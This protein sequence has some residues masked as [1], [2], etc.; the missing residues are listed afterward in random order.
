MQTIL[1]IHTATPTL[2]LSLLFLPQGRSEVRHWL[3]DRQMGARLHLCLQTFYPPEHWG[4]LAAIAVAVGPGS[5]TGC[6]LGV[7]LARTLGCTLEIPVFGVSTLAAVACTKFSDSA[8]EN[9]LAIQM[10]AKRGEWF[11]GIYS[12]SAGDVE[13]AIPDRLWSPQEWDE[14]TAGLAIADAEQWQAAPPV[15]AIALLAAHR[16]KRGLRPQWHEVQPLYGRQPP[17]QSG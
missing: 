2:G 6:R 17:I 12:Q 1:G 9:L 8:E 4:E 3:L 11:G 13:A 5:F 15:E 7:T 16:F 10:D 14:K